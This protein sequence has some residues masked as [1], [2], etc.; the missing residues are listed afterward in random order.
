MD[1]RATRRFASLRRAALRH[2]THFTVRLEGTTDMIIPKA[3]CIIK[4]LTPYSQSRYHEAAKKEK[5]LADAY[6]RR[7]WREKMHVMTVGGRSIVYIPAHAIHQCV[8]AAANVVAAAGGVG[9]ASGVGVAVARDAGGIA[10][11]GT[12]GDGTI[13]VGD[14]AADDAG[15]DGLAE[16]GGGAVVGVDAAF[17]NATE[18]DDIADAARLA[19]DRWFLQGIWS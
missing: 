16:P 11:R 4:G 8:V 5:E 6:D 18:L 7:T 9:A 1:Y 10:D 15:I 14:A 12:A 2:A 13:V 19:V 17:R 3:T